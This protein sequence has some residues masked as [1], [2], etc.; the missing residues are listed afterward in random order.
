MTATKELQVKSSIIIV[1][2]YNIKFQIPL[3]V[4]HFSNF[5]FVEQTLTDFFQ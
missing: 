4:K 3:S 1:L 5:Q 2:L